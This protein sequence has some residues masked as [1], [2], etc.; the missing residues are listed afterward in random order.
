MS[1]TNSFLFGHGFFH[2]YTDKCVQYDEQHDANSVSEDTVN[3]AKNWITYLDSELIG[4][5]IHFG[6]IVFIYIRNDFESEEAMNVE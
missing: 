3:G 4:E 2:L 5:W 1:A 6:E